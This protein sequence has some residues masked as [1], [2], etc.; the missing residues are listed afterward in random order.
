MEKSKQI[1][2]RSLL[3]QQQYDAAVSKAKHLRIIAGAGTGKTRALTYRIANL[4]TDQNVIPYRIVAITFTNKVANEMKER[5]LNIL[6]E[7]ESEVSS[8]PF[9]STYHGFCLKFLRSEIEYLKGYT[10]NFT[11]ADD[12]DQK[13]YFKD[14]A[15]NLNISDKSDQFKT[16][17]STIKS[18]KCRGLFPNDVAD[19]DIEVPDLRLV[20]VVDFYKE[21]QRLL[22]RSNTLDFD[23]ILMNTYKII[24]NNANIKEKYYH[25]YTTYLVDEYQDTNDLQYKLLKEFLGPDSTLTVVGDPDQTIYTWRGANANLIRDTLA[26]DFPDLET[27]VLNENYRSTQSILDSANLL[28]AKNYY[29]DRKDLK[30][31]SGLVGEEVTYRLLPNQDLEASFIADKIFEGVAK[32]H[33]TYK[34]VAIIYRSN[35]LSRALETALAKKR[36]PYRIYGGFRFFDRASIKS[37]LAYLKIIIN[38]EDEASVLRVLQS[39]TRGLGE[40]GIGRLIDFCGDNQINLLEAIIS[41]LGELNLPGK[42]LAELGRFREA[43]GRLIAHFNEEDIDT[44]D[45]GKVVL[46][47]LDDSGFLSHIQRVDAKN[48]E[49]EGKAAKNAETDNVHELVANIVSFFDNP[50]LEDDEKEVDYSPADLLALYLNNVMLMSQQDDIESV[51]AVSLMTVH[52]SKGLE[53]PTVFVSGLVEGIFPNSHAIYDLKKEAIEE[54]RRLLYVAITRAR[55]KIFLSSF[56][57]YSYIMGADNQPSSFLKE[58]GLTDKSLVR[59]PVKNTFDARRSGEVK[60]FNT[61]RDIEA[62]LR[63]LRE[64]VK[65]MQCGLVFKQNKKFVYQVGDKVI[66]TSYGVGEVKAVDGDKITAYFP[67]KADNKEVRFVNGVAQGYRPLDD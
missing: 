39:P 49:K 55:R 27:I 8:L 31:A 46:D 59:S 40:V 5:V 32:K 22:K 9:I 7:A 25:R 1:D 67:G 4:I 44:I 29:S 20:D 21:Y 3:N 2:Y 54:E 60:S 36:I 16:L 28:I 41:H 26:K 65:P 30:A 37:A 17:I 51:D 56:R 64:Q 18:L 24:K 57:G 66:S 14:T 19:T 15:K 47:Y 52:V 11:I 42:T 62:R 13:K 45:I 63:D 61:V 50:N 34:D 48:V 33:F 43:F 12:D 53:F 38:P 35:Y 6:H 10:R 58:L 23:D